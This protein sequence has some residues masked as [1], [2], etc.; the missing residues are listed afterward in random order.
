MTAKILIV[1]DDLSILEL[2]RILLVKEGFEVKTATNGETGLKEITEWRPDVLVLD[3]MMPK[4][5]GY[6]VA[7]IMEKDENLKK[8][9]IIQLTATSQLVGGISLKSPS[10]YRIQKPFQPEELLELINEILSK[11]N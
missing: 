4:M 8:I 3:I 10:P 5:S 1:D 9:P 6:M 7:A 11:Q 2:V